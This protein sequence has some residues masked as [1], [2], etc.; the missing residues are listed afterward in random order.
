MKMI[1]FPDTV[2]MSA[3]YKG[4]GRPDAD[5]GIYLND[6]K[7]PGFG[8]TPTDLA[9]AFVRGAVM[10]CAVLFDKQPSDVAGKGWT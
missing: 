6:K 7:K 2:D 10:L 4:G 5:P 9:K 1:V 3:V 8:P